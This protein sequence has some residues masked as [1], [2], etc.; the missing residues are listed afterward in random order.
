M[1]A[2]QRRETKATLVKVRDLLS[3][4]ANWLKGYFAC[5]TENR[6]V[7]PRSE[8]ACQWCLEGAVRLFCNGWEKHFTDPDVKPDTPYHR[9]CDALK[10]TADTPSLLKFNDDKDYEDVVKLIDDTIFNIEKGYL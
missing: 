3:D 8:N 2:K 1:N 7:S 4:E 10:D 5:D 9:V 6:G